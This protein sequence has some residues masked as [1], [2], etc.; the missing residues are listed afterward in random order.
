MDSKAT[1]KSSQKSSQKIIELIKMDKTITTQT[2]ADKIGIS[3]RAVAK[4][5]AILQEK[6]VIRRV[7]GAKGGYWEIVGKE[8]V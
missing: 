1:E 8:N 7:G 4:Q 6:K 5:I 2:M 3:R